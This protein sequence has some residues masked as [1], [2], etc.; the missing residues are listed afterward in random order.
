MHLIEQP[1]TLQF[2]NVIFQT[3]CYA[4]EEWLET[5]LSKLS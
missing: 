4:L 1:Y 2:E 5:P 3:D